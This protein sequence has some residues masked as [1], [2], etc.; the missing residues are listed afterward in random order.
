MD[1]LREGVREEGVGKDG[2]VFFKTFL[3]PGSSWAAFPTDYRERCWEEN[4]GERGLG[5]KTRGCTAAAPEVSHSVAGAGQT[6][7]A[8]GE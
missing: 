1:G 2:C 3:A 4:K 8:A 5:L 6:E 7:G